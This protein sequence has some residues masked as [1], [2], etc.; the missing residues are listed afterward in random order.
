[1]LAAL[2]VADGHANRFVGGGG[3]G[4]GRIWLGGGGD[5]EQGVLSELLKGAGA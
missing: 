1:L 5:L 4:G 2:V 3:G